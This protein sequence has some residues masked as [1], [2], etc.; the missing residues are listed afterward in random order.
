MGWIAGIDG[1]GS[2]TAFCIMNTESRKMMRAVFP[3][4]C[5]KDHGVEGYRRILENAFAFLDI[6]RKQVEAVCIGVP[7]FGEYKDLDIQVKKETE[8]LFPHAGI[9]CEND[10]FVGFAGA[11]GMSPGIHVISGTGAV[12]YGMDSMGKSARSNGWHPVFSDE[13]SGVWLG[14]AA[15]GLF[16]KEADGR[17]KKG[18]LF[19]TFEEELGIHSPAEAIAYYEEHC[20]LSRTELAKTQK[21]L[22]KAA[23]RGDRSAAELYEHAAEQLALS[24]YAVYGKLSFEE[25]V[26][27]SYSGGVFRAGEILLAPFRKALSEKIPGCR[28]VPP[29]YKPEEG[30]LLAAARLIG[31]SEKIDFA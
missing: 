15:F 31:Y 10:C 13:G 20:R 18:K 12:A 24:A 3:S 27:V 5:P 16:A 8:S 9:R 2:K 25:R 23:A 30:A 28:V 14:R 26:S 29:K 1:G 17:E 22:L 4:I 7:C 6:D 11:F 21:V 19:E